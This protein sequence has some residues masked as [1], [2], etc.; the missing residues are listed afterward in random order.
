MQVQQSHIE[1]DGVTV[2]ASE[3]FAAV[4]QNIA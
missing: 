1:E 3:E 2:L 4:M